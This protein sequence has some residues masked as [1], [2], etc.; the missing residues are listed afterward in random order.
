MGAYASTFPNSGGN[1][2]LEVTDPSQSNWITAHAETCKMSIPEVQKCWNRFL[3]LGPDSSGNI[4]RSSLLSK[5]PFTK[6]ILEQIPVVNNEVITFQ[7]YCSAVSWLAK[8]PQ[9]SKLRGL[10]HVLTSKE[11]KMGDIK[12]LLHH[13]YPNKDPKVIEEICHLLLSEIDKS[14]KGVIDEAQFVSWIRNLPKE[15]VT[16]VLDFRII[17]PKF[18]SSRDLD[19]SSVS[20]IYIAVDEDGRLRDDQLHQ[21]STA[22]VKAKRDWR[23][24][25][26]KLGF[27]EKDCI[28]FE[29]TH[30]ETKDQILDMLQMW[31]N[32]L[33]RPDQSQILQD[34]LKKTGN[35]DIA[36]EIFKLNF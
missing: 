13:L 23:L 32:T 5:K 33:S 27:L 11:L 26:N 7:T 30:H 12:N 25:A 10:W 18:Q 28:F 15:H 22:L 20:P 8:A 34:V 35:A 21:V 24:L 14:K 17:S 3:M 4:K 2:V 1:I 36:N 6:Q 16:S 9:E 29:R 19:L 31:R